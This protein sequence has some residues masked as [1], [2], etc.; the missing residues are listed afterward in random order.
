MQRKGRSNWRITSI[1]RG[2]SQKGADLNSFCQ[3]KGITRLP[4]AAVYFRSFRLGSLLS[5]VENIKLF[6]QCP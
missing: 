3:F 1:V 2:L 5:E 4:I 6:R